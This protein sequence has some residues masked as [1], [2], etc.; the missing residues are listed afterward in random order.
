MY[1]PHFNAVDDVGEIRHMVDAIGS[2]EIIT[3]DPHG[4][5]LATLLPIM[6]SE[7]GAT[8]V[9]HMARANDHWRAI[10]PDSRALA[11]VADAQAYIS[12]AW[13][14]SKAEH[15]RVVPTWN[16]STVHFTGAVTVRDDID[17]VRHAVT[18]LTERHEQARSDPWAVT[19]APDRFVAGQLKAIVGLEMT[20]ERVEAK[21]KLSQNRSAADRRG[22]VAGLNAEGAERE[23]AI[24][25]AVDSRE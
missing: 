14:A 23:H 18:T 16:Y 25:D 10:A 8:I 1:V 22:V 13:Y 6:W 20:V 19:D 21:A 7:D 9:A 3:V 11:I 24:A 17:W 4:T 15:G 12:P 2:A 5:P